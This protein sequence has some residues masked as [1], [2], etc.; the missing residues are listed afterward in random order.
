MEAR[1]WQ[2]VEHKPECTGLGD[3][4][5]VLGRQRRDK[6]R[7]ILEQSYIINCLTVSSVSP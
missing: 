7:G 1:G 6:R 5:L 4:V 2:N 3:L